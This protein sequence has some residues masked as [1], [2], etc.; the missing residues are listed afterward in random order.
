MADL[1]HTIPAASSCCSSETQGSCCQPEAKAECCGEHHGDGCGC[2]ESA[3]ELEQVRETV[4]TRYAAA[5]AS[6][7][8]GTDSGSGCC[9]SGSGVG[10]TDEHGTKVFG[11]TLYD[12]DDL[13]QGTAGAVGAS[14]GCGVPTAVADLH[15]GETVLDLGSGAGGDVLISARRV[16]ATGK[17]IGVDMTDEM[18]DLARRNATAGGVE[19]SS[20]SRATSKTCL[21]PMRASTSSSRTA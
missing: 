21:W 9:G 8:A 7:A 14:L 12:T 11:A 13:D 16:G 18:L 4:R 3:S 19:T 1:E 2:A 10:V 5:A 20:S 17:A 6:I 15:E